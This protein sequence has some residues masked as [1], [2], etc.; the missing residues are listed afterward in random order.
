MIITCCVNPQ[1]N[2]INDDNIPGVDQNDNMLKDDEK[3]GNPDP[4]DV[5]EDPKDIRDKE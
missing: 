1:N 4:E 2:G 5:I 3:D